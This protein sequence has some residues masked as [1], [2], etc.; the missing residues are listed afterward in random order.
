MHSALGDSVV[1]AFGVLGQSLVYVVREFVTAS[2][3]AA[4]SSH[5]KHEGDVLS[6]GH[7][8]DLSP[9]VDIF[10]VSVREE[11]D[12]G[13]RGG[14]FDGVVETSHSQFG[15]ITTT[16]R[17]QPI[18]VVHNCIRVVRYQ[19][20]GHVRVVVRRHH[21][22]DKDLLGESVVGCKDAPHT[23]PNLANVVS[24]GA[25]RVNDEGHRDWSKWVIGRVG[26]GDHAEKE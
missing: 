3:P 23:S 18:D 25:S 5:D 20:S 22:F 2:M 17:V 4:A 1:S 19:R 14:V 13:A 8:S 10:R 15:T 7:A 26:H 9:T 16:S 12:D 6:E 24:H 21:I 11:E